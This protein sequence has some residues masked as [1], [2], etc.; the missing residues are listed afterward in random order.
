M[1][2]YGKPT[3]IFLRTKRNLSSG[4][5]EDAFPAPL[6]GAVP[7]LRPVPSGLPPA[8]GDP[9]MATKPHPPRLLLYPL[10]FSPG[11]YSY[12]KISIFI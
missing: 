5:A 4:G 2:G 9:R 10:P 6:P 7:A 3:W 1:Y 11:R 12:L 8:S